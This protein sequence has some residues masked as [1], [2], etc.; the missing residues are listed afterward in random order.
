MG[1]LSTRNV[2]VASTPLLSVLGP[3][4]VLENLLY[5]IKVKPLFYSEPQE[6][7]ILPEYTVYV[8]DFTQPV[9]KYYVATSTSR[10]FSNFYVYGA[11]IELIAAS[12]L[13]LQ[14]QY[15]LTGIPFIN[16]RNDPHTISI[17]SSI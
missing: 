13:S 5:E 3:R 8:L 15:P 11:S 12:H 7:F 6:T 2:L 10:N 1:L 16:Y 9:T 4:I 17:N 14:D